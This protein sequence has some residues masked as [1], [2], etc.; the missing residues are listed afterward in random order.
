MP[1]LALLYDDLAE[2]YAAGRHLFDTTPILEEFARFLPPGSRV[3]DAGCGAG[4]PV[5]RHFVDRGDVVT[6]IDVS[7][8]MLALARRQAPEATFQRMDLRAL[9]F[10]P[11]SFDAI[12]AVYVVFHL[13]RAEHAALF[14]G[15]ARVL[16]P[17][18]ALLLTLATREYTGQDEFDGEMAF[19]GRRLPY[20]HDRPEVALG[21][22]HAV[23]LAVVGA[24]PIETGG[25]TFYW[26][27]ARKPH[28]TE[29]D[30]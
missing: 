26:V 10:L 12:A 23:G 18:G 16:K 29:G 30:R 28:P 22:L 11:A 8:R 7:E 4:E 15:F 17:G 9:D 20:S 24:R 1:D 13:P 19:L 2:T 6:G 21:K 14:A 3:L 27:I 5:A 25:E